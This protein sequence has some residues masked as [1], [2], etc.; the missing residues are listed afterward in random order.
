MTIEIKGTCN[1]KFAAVREAFEENFS[2]GGE[3]GATVCATVDGET[4][5]DLWAGHQDKRRTRPWEQ[6]TIVTVYSTTKTMAALVMLML[7]DRGEIDFYEPVAKYWPEFGQNGKEDI[8]VRHVMAHSAGLAGTDVDVGP[9]G[10]YSQD[11]MAETLAAQKPWWDDRSQ[12][13]YHGMTQGYL[14]AEIVRRVTGKTLGTFFAD[15]IAGPL[16]ADFFIGVPP[17]KDDQVCIIIPADDGGDDEDFEKAIAEMFGGR[18]SVGFRS[19]ARP[20]AAPDAA[21]TE[22]WR[23]AEIP[24]ANGHGNA[25]SVANVH[26]IIALGGEVDG[27]RF[28][29]REGVERIFDKQTEGTDLVLGVPTVFGMGFGLAGGFMQLG[30]RGC[31]WGGAGGSLAI[32]DTDARTTFAYVMNQ[33]VV[34]VVGD[35]RSRRLQAAFESSLGTASR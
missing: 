21:G 26:R 15:E 1:E 25:R 30:P 27:R 5:V 12:S 18:D 17:E 22:A 13:G 8:E 16:D 23:R 24:A 28:M 4:V 14:Q 31:S 2:A 9:D 10:L 3:V 7:A 6:D 19:F 33:M 11:K 29:S 20:R 32:I 35:E 34:T